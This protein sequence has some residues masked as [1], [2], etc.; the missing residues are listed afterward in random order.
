MMPRLPPAP[1]NA[2]GRPLPSAGPRTV[3]VWSLSLNRSRTKPCNCPDRTGTVDWFAPSAL[4]STWRALSWAYHQPSAPPAVSTGAVSK[5]LILLVTTATTVTTATMAPAVTQNHRLRQ[6]RRIRRGGRAAASSRRTPGAAP[7][8]AWAVAPA[9]A[10]AAS[11]AGDPRR[12]STAA[13][14]SSAASRGRASVMWAA[15]CS[16]SSLACPAQLGERGR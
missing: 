12:A 7:T 15:I 14:C 9:D 2:D 8:V 11:S 16:R 1:T 6:T 13:T 10:S 4:V 3:C 5:A